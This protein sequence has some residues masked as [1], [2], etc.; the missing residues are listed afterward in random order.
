VKL[1]ISPHGTTLL[2]KEEAMGV[3]SQLEVLGVK[4]AIEF[5]PKALAGSGIPEPITRIILETMIGALQEQ[6]KTSDEKLRKL[7]GSY[8]QSGV[9]YL[10]AA[11]NVTGEQ[12]S[13]WIN[14]EAL[15]AFEHAI[16]LDPHNANN[17]FNKGKMLEHLGRGKEAQQALNT[18][19]LLEK[20]G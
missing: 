17:H 19:K 12:R 16:Q 20:R 15:E 2:K 10:R 5:I 18:A 4:L 8:Y 7:V 3:E 11:D 6:Q 1:I 9:E 13:A 14:K